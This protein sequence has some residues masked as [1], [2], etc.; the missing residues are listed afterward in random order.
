MTK[1]DARLGLSEVVLNEVKELFGDRFFDTLIR[2]NVAI[3]DAQSNGEDVFS[4]SRNSNAALDYG[5]LATQIINRLDYVKE[6][7]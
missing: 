5:K 4:Y 7:R 1:Y 3:A 6:E 2:T